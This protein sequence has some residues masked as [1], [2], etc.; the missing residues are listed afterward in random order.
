VDGV[1]HFA[2]VAGNG[3][4][5]LRERDAA[6]EVLRAKVF[7]TVNLAK[8]FAGRAVPRF[9]VLASSRAAFEG[10]V[11]SGDYA[12]ANAYLD[13]FAASCQLPSR[14]LSIGFP[15]WSQVGMAARAQPAEPGRPGDVV[16]RLELSAASQ[17]ALDEHRVAG[18]PVMP[19]SG[20]L[21]LV[22]AA[23]GRVLPGAGPIQVSDLAFAVPLAVAKVHDA[24]IVFSPDG[25]RHRVAVYSR[26]RG[27]RQWVKHAS[28]WIERVDSQPFARDPGSTLQ[29]LSE[30]PLPNRTSGNRIFMLG[31]R[32]DAV[33]SVRGRGDD[34]LVQ[35]RLPDAYHRDLSEHVLHPSLLDCA[36][37]ALRRP[38]EEPHLPFI[39][40]KVV[41]FGPL[42]AR[43][44]VHVRRGPGS[45]GMLAGDIDVFGVDGQQILAIE[46]FKMRR[47]DPSFAPSAP[48]GA[49][50]PEAE[51]GIPPQAGAELI[52]R[53][54]AARTPEHVLIRPYRN[55]VPVWLP[56]APKPEPPAAPMVAAPAPGEFTVE[57]DPG[58][59]G[60]LRTL[61]Q[62]ALGIDD[63]GDDDDF[64]DLGGNSL[65]AV[66][67]MSRIRDAF[68]VELSIGLLFD[69]PK[70]R[71]LTAVI[72]KGVG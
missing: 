52:F 5:A 20:I 31:P 69:A 14:V 50:E 4:L 33:Q 71:A 70:L 15:S 51:V 27:A 3:M 38:D 55:G 1:F 13:G 32:W 44:V 68:G 16:D 36:T 47:V 35:L 57:E 41:V 59:P 67:L 63:I 24:R 30:Q 58:V 12:A 40:G 18:T 56:Q 22:V 72:E 49:P 10:L 21:D 60:R 29:G 54:L 25:A 37:G 45:P 43:A 7:G 19:G 17:W 34:L 64:F 62:Q 23:Y 66:E 9:V 53:L 2:G 39:Y 26:L 65:S 11:G 46:D 28:G 42:P 61:W 48:A 6:A 8:A